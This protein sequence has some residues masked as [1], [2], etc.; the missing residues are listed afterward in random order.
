[1]RLAHPETDPDQDPLSLLGKAPRAIATPCGGDDLSPS[2]A[3]DEA[4]DRGGERR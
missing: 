3:A 2:D 4:Q 1:V